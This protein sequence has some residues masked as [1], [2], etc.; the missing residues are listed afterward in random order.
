MN[1]HGPALKLHTKLTQ[2]KILS[3]S[4]FL[5]TARLNVTCPGR[6]QT[7]NAVKGGKEVVRYLVVY[8]IYCSNND[9]LKQQLK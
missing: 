9:P 6:I 5:H 3:D 4:A 8:F 1:V 2:Q 7:D